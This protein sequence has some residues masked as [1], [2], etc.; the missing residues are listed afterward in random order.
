MAGPFRNNDLRSP[1]VYKRF[2]R[3]EYDCRIRDD[4]R[5][6][7]MRFDDV[8]FEQNPFAADFIR[9]YAQFAETGQE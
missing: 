6:T 9:R 5:R 7:T 2:R 4:M 3:S 8:G 1:E